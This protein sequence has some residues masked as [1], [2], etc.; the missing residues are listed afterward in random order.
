M[1]AA[2]AKPAHPLPGI[3]TGREDQ[4]FI[5][6]PSH[7]RGYASL[8]DHRDTDVHITFI[9]DRLVCWCCNLPTRQDT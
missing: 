3:K 1:S 9:T 7:L 6:G 5:P 8:K 4:V 2:K